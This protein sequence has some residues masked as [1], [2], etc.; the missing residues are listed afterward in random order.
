MLYFYLAKSKETLINLSEAACTEQKQARRQRLPKKQSG[1]VLI[2]CLMI[3]LLISLLGL[4]SL[5]ASITQE[6][7]VHSF[8]E[9]NVTFQAAESALNYVEKNLL[10]FANGKGIPLPVVQSNYKQKNLASNSVVVLADQNY[11]LWQQGKVTGNA[12][13]YKS[14]GSRSQWWL[15]Q[16]TP[17][18]KL[19]LAEED[20]HYQTL[21]T[22]SAMIL[23]QGEFLPDDLSM[24]SRAEFRGRQAFHGLVRA[25]GR[26]KHIESTLRTDVLVRYQ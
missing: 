13:Y 10:D 22:Q 11:T 5:N 6:R 1:I 21:T 19:D 14:Q 17:Y 26:N 3:L 24:E 4:S 18:N 15:E 9:H 2:Y 12:D 7:M 16:A 25:E 8:H 20:G 23:E